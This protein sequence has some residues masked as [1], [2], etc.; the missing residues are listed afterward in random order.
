MTNFT[1]IL[2]NLI[3]K[4]KIDINFDDHMERCRCC[5]RRLRSDDEFFEIDEVIQRNFYNLT[6]IEVS[7]KLIREYLK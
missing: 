4:E 5:F 6:Q 7:R 2:E 1:P 3:K